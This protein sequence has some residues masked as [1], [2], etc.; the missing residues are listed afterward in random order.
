MEA[1]ILTRA[2]FGALAVPLAVLFGA[3]IGLVLVLYLFSLHMLLGL[4]GVVAL[5]VGVALFAR[6]ERSRF[7]SGPPV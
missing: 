2:A 3:V 6:W 7:H 5:V 4:G 1:L